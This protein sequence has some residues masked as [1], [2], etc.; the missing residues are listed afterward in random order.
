MNLLFEIKPSG[1]K[2]DPNMPNP[3]LDKLVFN[4][5]SSCTL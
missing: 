3:M 2:R 4:L 1:G 5:T